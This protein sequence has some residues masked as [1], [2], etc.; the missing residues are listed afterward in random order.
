M[1]PPHPHN[2][3][4]LIKKICLSSLLQSRETDL[5]LMKHSLPGMRAAFLGNYSVAGEF[6]VFEDEEEAIPQGTST[7]IKN[8]LSFAFARYGIFFRAITRGKAQGYV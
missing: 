6:P 4:D 2:D 8:L 1:V 5:L 7:Q 3:V